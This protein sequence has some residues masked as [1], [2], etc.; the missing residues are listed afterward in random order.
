[1]SIKPW[2]NAPWAPRRWQAEALPIVIDAIKTGKRALISAIMGSGKSVLI[3][4]LCYLA[5]K[6][7]RDRAIIIVAPRQ[8]LIVQLSS[9][10][11][12]RI[13]EHEVGQY[14]AKKKQPSRKVIVCCGA[15]LLN[16][17]MD[18]Q[19]EQRKVALMI[20]DEAHGSEAKLL[21]DIIPDIDPLCLVGFTATPFRSAPK[22]TISLF[23]TVIYRYTMQDALN[24]KVLV[25]MDYRRYEGLI[26]P[27]DLDIECYNMIKKWGVGPGIVSAKS[28][29]D[30]EN[31]AE[32][33]TEKGIEAK[34]IHSKIKDSVQRQLLE[35]LRSGE[36]QALVHV[37]LLSEGVDLP[38]LSW[39]CLR[40]KV[41]ARV[42]FLQEIGRV[43]RTN[44]GK[45]SGVVIDPHLLL[46]K[47]G[48][49]TAEAIGT[50]L[51]EIAELESAEEKKP[52]EKQLN[53]AQVIALD[54]L[55]AYLTKLK[56]EMAKE[57][58][59]TP[60]EITGEYWRL[61]NVSEKQIEVI[62]KSS[63]LTRHI[64]KEYRSPIKALL[65]VA[66]SLNRGEAADLLD[67]LI[68]GAKYCRILAQKLDLQPHFVK[69]TGNFNMPNVEDAVETMG[70][71]N[72]LN[73]RNKGQIH[74]I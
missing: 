18:L 49:V 24:D 68:G 37:A 3:A 26:E 6:N 63:R 23:N 59:I 69:W 15:S 45:S 29:E 60:K 8:N 4:E 7:L 51:E 28:I 10:I 2:D 46:G 25:P 38:W 19:A 16:L 66:W 12:Q 47:H 65:G 35:R 22:E 70:K 73:R 67:V 61:A 13:G 27:K 40:R 1:M 21:K 55:L 53:D 14:Y 5:T 42:R 39:I 20:V 50:A 64:P 72:E 54:I 44:E 33:L 48:L 71:K 11:K 74:D 41:E 43:L 52:R 17:W 31:Y 34:A 30:A 57:N 36:L 9:T 58:I 56:E 32:F 62:K